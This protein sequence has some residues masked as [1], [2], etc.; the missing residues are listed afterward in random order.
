MSNLCTWSYGTTN[1]V[2][3]VPNNLKYNF[4]KNP[5]FDSKHLLS[6]TINYNIFNSQSLTKQFKEYEVFFIWMQ[7]ENCHRFQEAFPKLYL[8]KYLAGSALG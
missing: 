5:K 7:V 8:E 1:F 4:P 2:R 3:C 6:H